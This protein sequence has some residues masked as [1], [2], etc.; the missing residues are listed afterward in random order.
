VAVT[1]ERDVTLCVTVQTAVMSR[2]VVIGGEILCVILRML[3][4][5]A[6]QTGR[7]M[8]AMC[9]RGVK[10]DTLCPTVDPPQ[11]TP[12]APLRAGSWQ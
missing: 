4:C 7:Q 5:V 12:L 1:Q 9:G 10:G 2:I 11:T 3:A 6:G 8:E